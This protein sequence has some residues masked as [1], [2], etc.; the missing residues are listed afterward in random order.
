MVVNST[1]YFIEFL[2]DEGFQLVENQEMTPV[3]FMGEVFVFVLLKSKKIV[4]YDKGG[5]EFKILE[6]YLKRKF[7]RYKI[8]NFISASKV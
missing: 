6:E 7:R 8:E 2:K 3:F 5:F 1:K 4:C